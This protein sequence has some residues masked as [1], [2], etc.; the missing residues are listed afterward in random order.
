MW[1]VIGRFATGYYIFDYFDP[2]Q[3]GWKGLV[4]TYIYTLSLSLLMFLI[5]RGM[6][7]LRDE[8]VRKIERGGQ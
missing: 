7:G 4:A 5:V 8:W 1:V 6:H 2:A 3:V